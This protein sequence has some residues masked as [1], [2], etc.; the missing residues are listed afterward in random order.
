MCQFFCCNNV[1]LGKIRAKR[2]REGI[3]SRDGERERERELRDCHLRQCHERACPGGEH[4]RGCDQG[5]AGQ[6][7][8]RQGSSLSLDCPCTGILTEKFLSLLSSYPRVIN[9]PFIV[10][11]QTHKDGNTDIACIIPICIIHMHNYLRYLAKVFYGLYT[12]SS[13]I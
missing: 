13:I 4:H 5:E 3:F 6:T 8:W 9:W 12:V 10:W 2:R 11:A 1:T 7:P